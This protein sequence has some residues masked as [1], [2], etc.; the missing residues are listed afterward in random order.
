MNGRS[1]TQII[2]IVSFQEIFSVWWVFVCVFGLFGFS[3][4]GFFVGLFG[5]VFNNSP[6]ATHP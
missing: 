1:T 5:F 4:V 3:V 6:S 2:H